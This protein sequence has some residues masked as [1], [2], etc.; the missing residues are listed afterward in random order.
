M[1]KLLYCFYRNTL[2]SFS[3]GSSL[4]FFFFSCLLLKDFNLSLPHQ[5]KKKSFLYFPPEWFLHTVSGH[6][7]FLVRH[8]SKSGKET[9]W[10]FHIIAEFLRQEDKYNISPAGHWNISLRIRTSRVSRWTLHILV[11]QQQTLPITAAGSSWVL[12]P[13]TLEFPGGWIL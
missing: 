4:S 7:Y 10:H 6:F 13:W 8:Y 5:E 2:F 3:F 12:T 1:L 11:N 9:S